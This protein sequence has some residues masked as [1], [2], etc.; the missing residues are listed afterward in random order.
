MQFRKFNFLQFPL[1]TLKLKNTLS[2]RVHI[3]C[4]IVFD[5]EAH[6]SWGEVGSGASEQLLHFGMYS[7]H[8]Y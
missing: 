5:K 4:D 2:K 6:C 7:V 8:K 1:S 3:T